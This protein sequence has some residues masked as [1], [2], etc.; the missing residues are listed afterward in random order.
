LL[1]LSPQAAPARKKVPPRAT[2]PETP[3]IDRKPAEVLM[4]EHD[5][6]FF[7]KAYPSELGCA[8]LQIKVNLL[9]NVGHMGMGYQSEALNAVS[10]KALELL[11]AD[12][13]K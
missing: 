10:D 12:G 4:S 2:I 11:H 3:W 1:L 13:Q 9:P 8:N 7:A 5:E 6:L